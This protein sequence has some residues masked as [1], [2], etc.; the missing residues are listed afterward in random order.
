MV[1]LPRLGEERE[2][3]R[4]SASNRNTNTIKHINKKSQSSFYYR[5]GVL[6][7]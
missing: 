2:K 3:N 7:N 4:S 5:D 1:A 6:Q